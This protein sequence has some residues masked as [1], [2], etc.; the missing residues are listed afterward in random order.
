MALSTLAYA[1]EVAVT[2]LRALPLERCLD[3]PP[4]EMAT[5]CPMVAGRFGEI[6][7]KRVAFVDQWEPRRATLLCERDTAWRCRRVVVLDRELRGARQRSPALFVTAAE[8]T[9]RL[10]SAGRVRIH[11]DF[12]V[13]PAP[14]LPPRVCAEVAGR[15]CATQGV[16]LRVND[17]EGAPMV[18][19]R[20]W[21]VEDPDGIL[22]VCSDATLTRCDELNTSAWVALAFT[23]RP[24]TLTT[25]QPP[26]ELDVPDTRTDRHGDPNARGDSQET[27]VGALDPF[28][29][30]KRARA[31]PP[32]PSRQDAERV[33]RELSTRGRGC[34]QSAERAAVELV[35]S[36]EGELISLLVDGMD[37]AQPLSVCLTQAT[38]KLALP[39]FA[40]ATYHLRAVVQRPP[41]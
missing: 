10:A 18:R 19:R 22:L 1:D 7:Q 13:L 2:N 12:G 29:R 15:A 6:D 33:A 16:R 41:R 28:L 34:L 30:P 8:L 38:R 32:H 4:A 24:S 36:G 14:R 9:K 20:L 40:S 31:L 37:A 26:P 21:W 17:R 11:E 27:A 25:A 39:R 5:R 35:W 23:L 3:L